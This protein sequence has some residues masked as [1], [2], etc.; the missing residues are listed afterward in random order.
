MGIMGMADLNTC[1][2]STN[3]I[4]SEDLDTSRFVSPKKQN[5]PAVQL[6]V[7]ALSKG[8]GWRFPSPLAVFR[9]PR[10]VRFPLRAAFALSGG[11]ESKI[12]PT[13]NLVRVHI[14]TLCPQE[15]L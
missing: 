6:V 12:R 7:P 3:H 11:T 9:L 10:A 2:D 14:G 1:N 13:E 4:E 5:R 8:P 15:S